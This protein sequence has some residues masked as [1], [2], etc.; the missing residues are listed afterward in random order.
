LFNDVNITTFE[1]QLKQKDMQPIRVQIDHLLFI[2]KWNELPQ[3]KIGNLSKA[4]SIYKI[5]QN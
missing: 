4:I 2:A 3:N 1:Y 5:T